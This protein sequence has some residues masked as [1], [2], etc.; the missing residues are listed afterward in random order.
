MDESPNA[1]SDWLALAADDLEML[2]RALAAPVKPGQACFHAQQAAEKALKAVATLQGAPEVPYTHSVVA[3]CRL[4]ASLGAECPI[5]E[6]ALLAFEPYAVRVRY[7][8]IAEPDEAA[9]WEARD[10]ARRIYDWAVEQAN[11][12]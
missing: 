6:T 5:E 7:R 2:E 10:L 8:R 3:L 1:T 9:A 4:V 12:R 11:Q